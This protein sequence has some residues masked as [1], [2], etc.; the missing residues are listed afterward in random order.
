MDNCH[1]HQV[2]RRRYLRRGGQKGHLITRSQTT[3]IRRVRSPS[4]SRTACDQ[5]M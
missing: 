1:N 3:Q 5:P 2:A 4:N